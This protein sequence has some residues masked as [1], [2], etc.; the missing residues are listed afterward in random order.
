MPQRKEE[1]QSNDNAAASARV[2]GRSGRPKLCGNE[3]TA[4]LG[5]CHDFTQQ[6]LPLFAAGKHSEHLRLRKGAKF[7]ESCFAGQ[8]ETGDGDPLHPQ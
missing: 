1:I 6:V 3:G 4:Q 5:V 8:E 2:R 7:K